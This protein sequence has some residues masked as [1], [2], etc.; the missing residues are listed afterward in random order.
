MHYDAYDLTQSD[1]VVWIKDLDLKQVDKEIIVAKE[2]MLSD[3]HIYAAHKLLRMQFPK[4]EGFYSTLLIQ[5]Q[6]FPAVTS[7]RCSGMRI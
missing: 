7:S 6:C 5:R 3:R 1:H 2:G 4:F